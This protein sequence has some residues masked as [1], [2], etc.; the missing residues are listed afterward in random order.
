MRFATLELLRAAYGRYALG[1]FNV[2]NMEQIHGLFRGAAKAQAPIIVQFTRVIRS[3]A[4]PAMLAGMIQ[5]AE[6]IYPEVDFAVH[7][8]HGDEA[9]CFEAVRSGHYGSVMIDASHLPF[10]QNV[11][12]TR[13]VVEK[14][15]ACG[16]AVEA[17]LG[18]L[19]GIEDD[20]A[21]SAQEAI[22]TDPAQ[23]EEFVRRTGCDS[24]AVAIGT[25]HGAY[26][27][28]GKQ[29]LHFDRLAEIQK[30]LP[31]FPLVLHG[32]SSVPAREVERINAAGG[33]LDVSASGVSEDE[34][35]RAIGLGITKVNV[36]TDG[37]LI[38]TRVHREFFK[39]KPKEF[40][41][42]SPGRSYMDAYAELVASK[43]ERLGA[44]RRVGSRSEAYFRP[45]EES[46]KSATSGRA[47]G[48]K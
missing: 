8:D 33:A 16:V 48:L 39:D 44:A 45:A 22:L 5:A 17:E 12:T 6:E 4:D 43:C 21:V 2:C 42:M 27:F 30:R 7:L 38:W 24:L 11:Q 35:V 29:R 26:K 1:A 20:M 9:S 46:A 28:S 18:L 37:R 10:E 34:L 19:K 47:G 13:Q 41:F 32:G 15:H 14:A 31:D 25:S 36:G 23:A 3:Y 40:D